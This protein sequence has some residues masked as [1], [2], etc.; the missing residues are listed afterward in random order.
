MAESNRY[1]RER[2]ADAAATCA[3]IDEVIAFLG[4][5]PYR[6]LRQHLYKRF[7]QLG[8]DVSHFPRRRRSG[9]TARPTKTE[10]QGAVSRSCSIAATL[11]S[12]K[13]PDSMRMRTLFHQWVEEDEIDT[14]HFLGQAQQRGKQGPI[15]VKTAEQVLVKHD[16]RRRTKTRILR[17]CLLEVGI[18]ERC[19]RCGTGPEWL[20]KP[21]T[22]EIDHINGDWS[23]NR[24]ENLRL[25]CPNCH[26]ITSTWCRG[27]DRRKSGR[28]HI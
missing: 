25:M 27:G 8:I 4:T 2:L 21:M 3:D 12:L 5:R 9:T 15:P 10:L 28:H 17:R 24:A 26:A 14:S 16:G 18:A 20:G 1:T 11:R 13:Q 19:A 23:D 22:L 7:E 6:N